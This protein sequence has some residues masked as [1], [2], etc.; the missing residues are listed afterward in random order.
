M[1]KQSQYFPQPCTTTTIEN[2]GQRRTLW[3]LVTTHNNGL[4][5]GNERVE[6][7]C[8]IPEHQHEDSEEI[9]FIYSGMAKCKVGDEERIVSAG[10]AVYIPPKHPHSINNLSDSEPLLLTWTLTPPLAVHQFV[11]K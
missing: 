11:A 5:F 1:D 8:V 7:G 9:L 4:S 3:H 2:E 6:P 10:E